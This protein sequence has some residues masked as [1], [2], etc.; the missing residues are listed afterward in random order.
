MKK[1]ELIDKWRQDKLEVSLAS[2]IETDQ[3]LTILLRLENM[4]EKE[5]HKHIST[6]DDEH[7]ITRYDDEA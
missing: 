3:L 1:H 2:I 6:T 4:L 5:Q 7:T